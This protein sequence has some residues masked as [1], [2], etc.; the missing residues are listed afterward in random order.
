MKTFGERGVVERFFQFKERTKNSG[1]D[2]L[3]ITL[4]LQFR[5]G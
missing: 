5:V 4:L 3:S 1:I 2:F